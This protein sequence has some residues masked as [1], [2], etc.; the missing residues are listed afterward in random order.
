MKDLYEELLRQQAEKFGDRTVDYVFCCPGHPSSGVQEMN[1]IKVLMGFF[2]MGL[3]F[4]IAHAESGNIYT[5]RN[6]CLG[7]GFRKDQKPFERGNKVYG[8]YKQMIW[9]DSDS[10]ITLPQV[11]RLISHDVDIVGAWY[12]QYPGAGPMERHTKAACGQWELKD[13]YSKIRPF[14]IDEIPT[15]PRNEK[16]LIEVDYC[17]FGLMVIKHGV[18]ESLTYPWFRSWLIEWIDDEG[19]ECADIQTDDSGL[20]FRAKEKGYKVLIDPLCRIGH[21][22]KVSI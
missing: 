11:L 2:Q 8:S 12:R 19:N 9:V 22:K 1:F 16:G 6:S 21:E 3:T 7:K 15:M 10:I 18:F 5:V 17:G 4:G 20:C 14:H 13:G